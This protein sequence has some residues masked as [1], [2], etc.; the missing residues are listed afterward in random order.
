MET[1]DADTA[2]Q[3]LKAL[4][5]Q[6]ADP[7]LRDTIRALGDAI[8]V[9]NISHASG[10]AVGRNIR[11]VINHFSVPPE[12]AA[13]L[14]ELRLMLGT[15]LSLEA[16]RYQLGSMVAEKA[17]EFVGREYVFTAINDFLSSNPCGY[18]IIE[19]DP[20][21]GKSALLAEFARRTASIAHFNVRSLGIN[22]A[23]Q[24]I[25]SVCAQLVAE[26]DLPYTTLPSQATEDGAFLLKVIEEAAQKLSPDRLLIAIDALDEVDVTTHPPGANILFL[27]GTLPNGVYVVMTR[28][29][30]DLPFVALSPQRT[31]NMMEYR[32][33]NRNDV[34]T[35]LTR[36]VVRPSLR[37]WID[38]QPLKA[39]AKTFTE[40]DFVQQL[41][42][43]SDNNFMYL[44]YVLPEIEDGAYKTLGIDR[45]P[46]G[47]E[48]YY[49]DHW[50]LMGMAAKPLP[51]VK[52]RIV[53][54]LCEV[55]QPVSRALISQFASNADMQ[56][57]ELTVQEVLEDWAQF[58]TKHTATQ[59]VTYNIYHASFRDFLHRKDIVIAAGVTIPGINGLIVDNLWEGLFGSQ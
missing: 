41:A 17:R 34:E 57:D 14:L 12:A 52:I 53:Y 22:T 58:L 8:S 13:A 4:A 37:A 31:L 56:I 26:A 10:V 54:I 15:A 43:L 16:H 27:P 51:R 18:F 2:L 24:F 3:Q 6:E 33:E 46:A 30:V 45:L 28:R 23:G 20:G 21:L 50:R 49:N 32:S 59:P 25:Q 42:T 48:G 44:R 29:Q 35:Y 9:G 5:S 47:L 40:R 19:G 11:Q 1:R 7:A 38:A 55:R 36:A 39:N